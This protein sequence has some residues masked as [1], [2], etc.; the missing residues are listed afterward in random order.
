MCAAHV[1]AMLAVSNA[2]AAAATEQH[3]L[4]SSEEKAFLHA[5][6]V[7]ATVLPEAVELPLLASVE[8]AG[9]RALQQGPDVSAVV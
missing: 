1:P 8:V 4:N 2:A 5:V 3:E 6:M 7:V 9:H